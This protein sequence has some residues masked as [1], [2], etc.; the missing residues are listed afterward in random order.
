MY[1]FAGR[2]L[3]MVNVVLMR[4]VCCFYE[5]HISHMCRL[6]MAP[7]NFLEHMTVL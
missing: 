5:I 3:G 4:L 7:S 6:P 2:A 1:T